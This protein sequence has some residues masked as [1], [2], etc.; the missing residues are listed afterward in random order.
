MPNVVGYRVG[1]EVVNIAR[2]HS[3]V[4]VVVVDTVGKLRTAIV[5][6]AGVTYATEISGAV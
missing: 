2:G 5:L 6:D 1:V 3:H 4:A